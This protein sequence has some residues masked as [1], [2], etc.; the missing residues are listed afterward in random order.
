MQFCQTATRGSAPDISQTVNVAA[1]SLRQSVFHC[2]NPHVLTATTA[3]SLLVWDVSAY[4][5][6][7]DGVY[8]ETFKVIPL[9]NEPI[10]CLAMTDRYP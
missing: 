1:G 4:F 9:Q 2:V 7:A 5:V 10:T 3:G 8:T 6:S